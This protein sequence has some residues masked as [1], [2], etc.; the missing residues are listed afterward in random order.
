[1]QSSPHDARWLFNMTLRHTCKAKNIHD[2]EFRWHIYK[3]MQVFDQQAAQTWSQ[4]KAHC[5][6]HLLRSEEWCRHTPQRPCLRLQNSAL[7]WTRSA[8]PRGWWPSPGCQSPPDHAWQSLWRHRWSAL[9]LSRWCHLHRR[10]IIEYKSNI[11]SSHQ[12]T[13]MMI[14]IKQYCKLLKWVQPKISA[15]GASL[16]PL[17]RLLLSVLL[18]LCNG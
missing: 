2:M 9:C 12:K 11:H 1:M 10:V 5:Q 18:G 17:G 13:L 16:C 6:Q 15:Y 8:Q 14:L 7:C 3:A 4:H